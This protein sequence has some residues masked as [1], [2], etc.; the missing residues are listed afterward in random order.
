MALSF[1]CK[2]DIFRDFRFYNANMI[3]ITGAAGF[4]GSSLLHHL[5]E[6]TEQNILVVDIF[7]KDNLANLEGARYLK[8]LDP[9]EF[10]EKF[11]KDRLPAL[12]TTIYHM[13]ACSSTSEEDCDYLLKTNT[14]YT[15]N[16]SKICLSW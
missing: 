1:F 7:N 5:T 16:L 4:I 8:T 2:E 9:T 6:V 14:Y 11:Q 15:L 13:G 3:V 12:P 10:L